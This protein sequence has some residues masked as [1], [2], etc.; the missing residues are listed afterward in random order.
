MRHASL[1][2]TQ[3]YTAVTDQQRRATIALLPIAG[4]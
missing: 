2:S 3:V 4:H 1:A